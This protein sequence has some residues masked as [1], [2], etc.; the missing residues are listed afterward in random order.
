MKT[1]TLEYILTHKFEKTGFEDLNSERH[2]TSG[3]FT[4]AQLSG[5]PGTDVDNMLKLKSRMADI[6]YEKNIST[7][8]F[9]A[10]TNIKYNSFN[11]S[12]NAPAGTRRI[13]RPMLAKFVVGLKLPLD[14]AN[15]LFSLESYPLSPDTVLLD[16]I[17]FH[18]IEN[19]YG[20]DELFETA[21]QVGY[22]IKMIV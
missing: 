1:I 5:L 3:M 15:E 17:V 16:A 10:D 13:S 14:V 19:N 11:K 12:I 4:K 18:C 22:D 8:K 6:Y 21:E 9:E 7:A 2:N 20:I